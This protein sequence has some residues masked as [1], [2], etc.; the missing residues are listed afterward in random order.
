MVTAVNLQRPLHTRPNCP[1]PSCSL[2][3]GREKGEKRG[4]RE[5]RRGEEKASS[6]LDKQIHAES[7][8]KDTHALPF[9]SS[10]TLIIQS[11]PKQG[12]GSILTES[13]IVVSLC[14]SLLPAA[15]RALLSWRQVPSTS[16]PLKRTSA[17]YTAHSTHTHKRERE[18]ERERER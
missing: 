14:I 4:G 5:E 12:M 10:K 13:G 3:L 17:C 2:S 7:D 18:R 11:N 6:S 9:Q 15:H 16:C 1:E 8:T